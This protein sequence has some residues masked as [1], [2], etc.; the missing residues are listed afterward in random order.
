MNFIVKNLKNIR[1]SK[2]FLPIF[3][4]LIFFAILFIFAQSPK[5]SSK[6]SSSS[7]VKKEKFRIIVSEKKPAD[8]QDIIVPEEKIATAAP[9]IPV[10]N[11]TNFVV[12]ID[13]G[14]QRK[15]DLSLEPIA[16]GSSKTK[17]KVTGG[18]TGV[19]T[20]TP[21]Y[22]ITLK[23]SLVLK[24]ILESKKIKVVMTR[25]VNDV[26]VSNI[27][28]AQIANKAKANLFVRIHADGNTDS[29]VNGISTLYPAKSSLSSSIFS[30]SKKA[31]ELIQAAVIKSTKRYN[32]GAKQRSDLSGFN[33]SKVPVILVE[34][35]FLSNRVEDLKLSSSE[36]QK[37]IA[38]GMADG[39][40]EFMNLR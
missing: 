1:N 12:C 28:R 34:S 4:A 7:K 19:V 9:V 29:S 27:E 37:R 33:W 31:A 22:E 17:P 23:I 36:E 14:H 26:N 32:R 40:F 6:S 11:S 20:R 21:E 24:N 35:G 13:P 18:A 15:G 38:Q 25:N 16:P 39:I 3:F 30:E 8:T 10:N 2:I 5:P